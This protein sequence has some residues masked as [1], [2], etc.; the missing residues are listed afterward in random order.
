MAVRNPEDMARA[1]QEALNSGNLDGLVA[2]YDPGA[3]LIPEPGKTVT[4]HDGIRQALSGFLAMK[5]RIALRSTDIMKA[6]DVAVIYGAW[7]LDGTG[8]DGKPA[9]MEGQSTEVLR[10]Q[11]DGTWRYLF[12]DPFSV[13]AA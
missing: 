2:L 12:D 9:H 8:P 5:P 3:L 1:W 13:R 11:S 10:R 4:G 7:T 6:G